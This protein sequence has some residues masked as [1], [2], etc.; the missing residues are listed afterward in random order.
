MQGKLKTKIQREIF[1][2]M[3][4]DFINP[5]HELVLLAK[6]IDWN[7]FEK[8][9]AQ[10]YS[11]KGAPSVPIRLMVGCLL[12]KYLYNLGDDSLPAVW[13][14]DAY[15][16]YF[17]GNVFFE[18]K[19][20]F[21][22]SDFVHFRK[23]IGEEGI[24]KIFAY[25]VHLHGKDVATKTKLVLSDTTV[26]ENN[27]T[28]PTDAKLCKK[29]IDRCNEIAKENDLNLRRSYT[30]E[31]KQLLR[32]T[33][34]SKHPRRAKQAKRAMKRLRTIS[35]VQLRD[36][37]RKLPIDK[38]NE[39]KKE[40]EILEKAANQQKNDTSKIYSLHKSFT[41]CIA[42]GKAHKPYEFGNKVGL[43]TSG[44][45][46]LK[47]ITAIK[48]FIDNVYDGHTIEP[49]LSQMEQNKLPLPEILA[50]DR[51]GR[52]KKEINGIKIMTPD[53]PKKTDT[54]YQKQK[55]RSIFR[56]RAA[57]EPIIGHLKTNFRM[58]Q[59]YLL[60]ETGAQINAFMA[61]IA[62]NLKKIMQKLKQKFLFLIFRT[63]FL[64]VF[65]YRKIYCIF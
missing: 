42:K 27:T 28:F 2:P 7:Y 33:H 51:G 46:G 25:S 19:F 12:L 54:A 3:L 24:G 32:Q 22:P 59:N 9:F 17:C 4:S 20:P 44:K 36:L 31:S 55:K 49:L 57:I 39:Y 60:G 34:N 21:D 10:Y 37:K 35:N 26:Q 14:R 16:Q 15:F 43:I 52:G 61:A 53:K 48:V 29:V 13:V 5:N 30:R 41:K 62:W 40:L 58:A 45:K 63:I 38:Q 23:R 56:S 11:N 6:T 50:Y 47:I 8:E 18:H 1:R 64:A 65:S